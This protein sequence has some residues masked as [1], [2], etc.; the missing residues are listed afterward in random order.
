MVSC[1]NP[2]N[3][4]LFLILVFI[5]VAMVLLLCNLEFLA[6][7][8]IIV[9]VGAI[10]VLFLFIVMMINIRKIERD[11]SLY[12]TVG[13][14]ITLLFAFQMYLL[15]FHDLFES[16]SNDLELTYF[17]DYINTNNFDEVTRINLLKN[18]GVVLF[19]ARPFLVFL[20]GMI[21]LVAMIGAI[22]LTNSKQGFSM[23][24]Q[25][26]QL[27]RNNIIEHVNVW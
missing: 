27:S 26:D 24:R 18:L 17:F 7:I 22:Y 21:L 16:F 19:Y 5:S 11:N 9:Y 4:V 8:L 10:A 1:T 20:A 6:L 14:I 23:K 13:A 25:Y 12:L 15:L 2:I 3:A